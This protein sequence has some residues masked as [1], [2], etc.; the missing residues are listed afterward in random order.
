[1]DQMQD[2]GTYIQYFS[3]ADFKL[4]VTKSYSNMS[5]RQSIVNKS[6]K[7]GDLG[8]TV[9]EKLRLQAAGIFGSLFTVSA[10]RK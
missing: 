10:D 2:F 1:M 7:F 3:A 4:L 8:Q 9:L 6:V 5:V